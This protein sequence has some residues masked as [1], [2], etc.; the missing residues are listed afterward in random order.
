[1][2]PENARA[3]GTGPAAAPSDAIVENARTLAEEAQAVKD[4]FLMT[5]RPVPSR[6]G[7]ARGALRERARRAPRSAG[8]PVVAPLLSALLTLALVAG[9]GI[10]AFGWTQ[11]RSARLHAEIEADIAR[12]L[13]RHEARRQA[14]A[15][16]PPRAAETTGTAADPQAQTA[17]KAQLRAIRKRGAGPRRERLVPPDFT[18]LPLAVLRGLPLPR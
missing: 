18:R 12:I 11:Q 7:P 13:Q 5:A 1:M 2:L 8:M 9:L 6:T 15:A 16:L 4:Y 14:L 10:A 3:A 17:R